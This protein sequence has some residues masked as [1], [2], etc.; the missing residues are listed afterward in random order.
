MSNNYS[1]NGSSCIIKVHA[2]I[3]GKWANATT[4][5]LDADQVQVQVQGTAHTGGKS[6]HG[7]SMHDSIFGRK[8]L[9]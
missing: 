7:K 8:F 3:E 9:R 1:N 4:E 2:L 6:M 5:S